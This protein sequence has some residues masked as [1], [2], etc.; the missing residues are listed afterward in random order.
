[1]LTLK[2]VSILL[3]MPICR[4]PLQRYCNAKLRQVIEIHISSP[5]SHH[6]A[7]AMPLT[8]V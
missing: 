7:S 1:M 6:K 3:F 2:K 8:T 5:T 4:K